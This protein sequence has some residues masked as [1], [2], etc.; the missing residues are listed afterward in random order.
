MSIFF[1]KPLAVK[2]TP[3]LNENIVV[4]TR[5]KLDKLK[6]CTISFYFSHPLASLSFNLIQTYGLRY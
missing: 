4:M 1:V 5:K 3:K 2:L 6:K